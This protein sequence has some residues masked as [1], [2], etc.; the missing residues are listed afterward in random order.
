MNFR[1]YILIVVNRYPV[2]A[3]GRL[4]NVLPPVEASIMFERLERG[5][6]TVSECMDVLRSDKELLV[7]PLLSGLASMLVM[8]SFAGPIWWTGYA[9][10]LRQQK[11]LWDQPLVWAISF[12]FYAI[13]Y[14][15]ILF[16]N[17]ALTG[18]AIIRFRGGNPTVSD[19][20]QIA[21]SRLP[22]IVSWA[23]LGATVG[24]ILK[25]L[26]SRSEKAGKWASNI[27]GIVW[28]VATFFVVPVLVVEGVGPF[29][30]VKRSSKVISEKWGESFVADLG[31]GL[32]SLLAM[33]PFLI[34]LVVGIATL[35]ST[36]SRLPEI[37]IALAVGGMILVSMASSTLD[38]IARTGLYM[39]AVD[40]KYLARFDRMIL[41]KQLD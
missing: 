30:A 11:E 20:F 4:V 16:F 22:Q 23:L 21:V 32:I 40:E 14:F 7:F 41:S 33:S 12:A 10:T 24:M 1:N 13:N 29:D 3:V 9:E 2:D 17:S 37:L 15:V 27:L 36:N 35:P 25:S 19:G 18:C 6:E 5:L 8:A 34:L 38:A 39:Q 31:L 26:E 28:S